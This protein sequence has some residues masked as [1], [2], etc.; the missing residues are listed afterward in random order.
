MVDQSGYSLIPV[1]LVPV[2][3]AVRFHLRPTIY[4]SHWNDLHTARDDVVR[5]GVQWLSVATIFH[6]YLA[7]PHHNMVV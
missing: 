4:G 5:S 2:L 1:S 3:R 7:R 6:G